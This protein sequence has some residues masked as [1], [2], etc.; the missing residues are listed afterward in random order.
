MT[1][2]YALVS[3]NEVIHDVLDEIDRDEQTNKITPE[4]IQGYI[5]FACQQITMKYPVK[6]KRL[7][8]LVTDQTDYLF[9]DTT[10]PVAGTGSISVSGDEV[11]GD[12]EPGSGTISTVGV[13][14]TGLLTAF[15]SE[16][17]LGE[18]IV[19]GTQ[20][21]YVIKIDDELHCTLNGGFDTDLPTGTAFDYS[22]TKFTKELNEGS[23]VVVGG[24]SRTIHHIKDAYNATV[25]TAFPADQV[26]QT[27][28]IDTKVTEIPTELFSVDSI[29]RR[30][31]GFNLSVEVCS[32]QKIEAQR[33]QD[34]GLVPYSNLE[35]PYLA[36]PWRNASGQRTLTFYPPVDRDKTVTLYGFLRLNP[37]AHRGDELTAFIPLN[38]EFIPAI[39][40]YVKYR[41]YGR[42]DQPWAQQKEKNSFDLFNS[43]L[44]DLIANM[45]VT[46]TRTVTT[47]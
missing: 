29:D 47:R 12:T 10:V 42:I 1:T 5:L 28:T 34:L 6:T 27:F 45:E 20:K 25:T 41:I 39:K 36:A 8:R 43:A 23:V 38:E 37:T 17:A 9:S 33:Q 30:D 18:M 21:R 16:L 14:V 13:E 44:K 4:A 35:R 11:I 26:S 24:I 15:V 31:G 40:E 7:L 3:Y 2:T 22:I 46:R 32:I 19:V